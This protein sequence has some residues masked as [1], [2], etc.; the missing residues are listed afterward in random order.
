M[1]YRTLAY[2]QMRSSMPEDNILYVSI[3]QQ[4][5]VPWSNKRYKDRPCD[6]NLF[7]EENEMYESNKI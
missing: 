3:K 2:K 6:T 5:N 1:T 7:Q 4:G